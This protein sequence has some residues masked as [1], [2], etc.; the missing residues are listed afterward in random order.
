MKLKSYLDNL[1]S[2]IVAGIGV[3]VIY[4]YTKYSGVGLS[5]DSIMYAST[6]TNIQAHGSLLTFNGKPITFFPIFYPVFLGMVQFFSGADPFQAGPV[7]D[8]CLFAAVIFLSGWII[9]KFITDSRIWTLDGFFRLKKNH[10]WLI[11]G[12]A[13]MLII[14]DYIVAYKLSINNPVPDNFYWLSHSFFFKTNPTQAYGWFLIFFRLELIFAILSTSYKRMILMLILMSPGLLEIYTYLWSET[15]Y[16]LLSMLFFIAYR[17]YLKTHSLKALLW[18]AL[19]TALACITRYVGVTIVGAGGL[20]LLLDR[21]L[22]I[23][24]KIQHILFFGFIS[25]SLLAGNLVLNRLTTGLSTGTREPSITPFVKNL[26]FSG[27]ILCDWGSLSNKAYTFAVPIMSVILLALIGYVAWRAWKNNMYNYEYI[28]AVYAL[29]YALFIVIS[30]SISRYEQIDSRLLAPMFIPLLI[31]CT[32]WVPDV[33]KGMKKKPKYVLAALAALLMLS[34]EWA[35]YQTDWQRYDDEND[36]GVPGYSDD[37]WNKSA[38]VVYL[39]THKSIFKP[40][41]PIYT[42]ADDAVYLFTGMSSK[43]VPHKYFKNQVAAFYQ[44]KNY[45]IIWFNSLYDPE[46]I[47]LPDIQKHKKLIEVGSSKEGEV[48]YCPE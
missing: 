12:A 28:L 21:E 39:R 38:F 30:A 4:L 6:G 2:L 8:M 31:A 18:P 45:Y 47:N 32:S 20:L 44:K 34:F 41:V 40:G 23:R 16:I 13:L 5:P 36:Y 14:A 7:I 1:D 19:I 37:S 11:G 43:L 48:F 26:Y 10:K 42:D 46:L 3:F 9:S 25:V 22:P 35:S 29:V 17:H 27:T 15:L 24:K 33:L